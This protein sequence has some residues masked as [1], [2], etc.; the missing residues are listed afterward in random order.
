MG[1][2]WLCPNTRDIISQQH[3]TQLKSIEFHNIKDGG[4]SLTSVIKKLL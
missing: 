2:R 1:N 4:R 3:D